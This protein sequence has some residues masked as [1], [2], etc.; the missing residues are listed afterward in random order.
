MDRYDAMYLESINELE[1]MRQKLLDEH[2]EIEKILQR[3]IE[4]EF[5]NSTSNLD[6][7]DYLFAVFF[8]IAGAMIS[9]NSQIEKFLDQIHK[10]A[11]GSKGDSNSVQAVIGN[12]LKHQG[13]AI[14][15]PEGASN[16]INRKGGNS[17]GLFHRLFWGHDI[18]STSDDNPF[19]LM[20]KSNGL[21][22]GIIQASRH[23]I[24]DTFSKQG[25][26]L[27]GSSYLDYMKDDGKLSNTLLSISQ[28]LAAKNGNKSMA[29]EY[30]RH[31]FTIRAQD[32][33][34]QGL[35]W[36]SAKA[37][38]KFRGIKDSIRQR[39]Y[40]VISYSVNFIMHFLIGSLKQGGVPYISWPALT[41]VVKELGGLFLTSRK[42]VKRLDRIT[43][44]LVKENVVL[45]TRGDMLEKQVLDTGRLLTIRE[46]SL[47][48]MQDYLDEEES[49]LD[50]I[51][52]LEED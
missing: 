48:Y 27:P 30:Y 41:M 3:E 40:K 26:P 13:D 14:D 44:Q 12:L 7:Y 47:E 38:F 33:A 42:E 43:E 49:S 37:Y 8:G 23:L 32:I 9:T 10:H 6:V 18:L 39:Q 21:L 45:I 35:V 19:C 11:S 34:A 52:F 25:L 5:V 31:M 2:I 36:A 16:F 50:F 17:Y 51:D 4:L 46:S 29:H 15:I 1:T 28:E 22:L 20:V 24:A